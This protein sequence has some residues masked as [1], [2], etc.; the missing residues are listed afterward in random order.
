MSSEN[1]IANK[2]VLFYTLG[3]KVNSYENDALA[4]IFHS[5]GAN[6]VSS[7]CLDI[8]IAI[9]NTC[10][11]TQKADQK[12]RQHIRKIRNTFPNAL[13]VVMGCHAQH[14]GKDIIDRGDADIV[15]GVHNRKGIIDSINSYYKNKKP[16]LVLKDYEYI[17]EEIVYEEFNSL[18]IIS[19][20]RA[21]VKISDGCD[22]FCSYCIIPKTRG[23]LRSRNKDH[24]LNEIKGL[25]N[26]GYKE[27]VLTGIHTGGYGNDLD[28]YKFSDLVEDILKYNPNLYRLRI[29]SIEASEI[30]DK[31]IDILKTDNR[32]ASHFHIPLQS[33]SNTVL[34]RM[35]RKYKV[36]EFINKVN[37]IKD[38][39][40]DVSI[41]TDIIVGF[42][43]E[44]NEEF[45]ET[46]EAVKTIEFSFVHVFPFSLR[47]GTDACK[48]ND[49]DPKIKKD[50]VHILSELR[51][52]YKNKY[53]NKFINQEV[54]ILIE[55]YNSRGKY[56]RGHTSN[57][58]E[59]KVIN[60]KEN[61]SGK[62]VK[63]KIGKENII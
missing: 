38:A 19:H 58:L 54:E 42:P 37:K 34:E 32:L 18:P 56:Y 10:S 51:D 53:D 5:F 28:N 61:L 14:S 21:Y 6:I 60:E 48:Y 23:R 15:Y 16:V 46:L 55:D 24:I 30:D 12:S 57:Y 47:E 11:V 25:V 13:I 20:T 7:K 1:Y 50:R 62:I 41:T 59:I 22:N 26:K 40:S 39:R 2:N 27:I 4:S 17:R 35:H 45:N 8:D 49:L 33:G 43:N 63:V 44:T 52:L 3:C 29:S 9:I 31:L 36:E